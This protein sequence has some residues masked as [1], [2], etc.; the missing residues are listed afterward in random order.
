MLLSFIISVNRFEILERLINFIRLQIEG[1]K[2]LLAI[3]IGSGYELKKCYDYLKIGILEALINQLSQLIMQ[4]I[5][6]LI[7]TIQI[8]AIFLTMAINIAQEDHIFLY[9][10]IKQARKQVLDSG[11]IIIGELV[12]PQ[13]ILPFSEKDRENV[14]EKGNYICVAKKV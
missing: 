14:F 6:V 2:E 1:P 13:V 4:V 3:G 12:T 9:S 8:T 11:L 7:L 10:S 5:Y